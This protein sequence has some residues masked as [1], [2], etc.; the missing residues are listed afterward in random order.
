MRQVIYISIAI[1]MCLFS[2]CKEQAAEKVVSNKAQ[3]TV[4]NVSTTP[5]IDSLYI[6]KDTII[7][8]NRYLLTCEAAMD[9]LKK[10]SYT[11]NTH[12]GDKA[13]KAVYN[14]Y[15]IRYT[16]TLKERN[17]KQLFKKI[18]TK[19]DFKGVIC[20]DALALTNTYLPQFIGYHKGFDAFIFILDF[21]I[22]DSD[23]GDE[24]FLMIGKDGRVIE[25]FHDSY[26]G[27]GGHGGTI[28][29]PSNNAFVLTGSTILNTNGKRIDLYEGD[30]TVVHTKLINNA[31]ILVIDELTDN[32]NKNNARL[33]N[34]YG[35]VL[36]TFT[37]KG[38]YNMLGYIVPSYI[39]KNT[40]CYILLDDE[41]KNLRLINLKEPTNI[42]TVPFKAPVLP[43]TN[44]EHE[45][46]FN[47]DTEFARRTFAMD[48]ITKAIRLIKEE[49]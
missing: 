28:E 13:E 18:F 15:D 46:S 11:C 40:G 3:D 35:E 36:K 34:N 21:W 37:Y 23:V 10:V 16:I 48:T 4:Y 25:K 5:Y 47:I 17:G 31:T 12:Q 29:F 39:E 8:S 27:G 6:K 43:E 41:L 7:E 1:I 44:R 9:T 32:V 22:P 19:D 14:G 20:E 38:Y 42:I 30:K 24:C 33:I 45:V 49:Q 26:Y 2:A